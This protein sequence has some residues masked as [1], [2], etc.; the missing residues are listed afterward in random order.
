[1]YADA[2]QELAKALSCLG[3]FAE[4][5][6]AAQRA[7]DLPR[8]AEANRA[9]TSRRL[10]RCKQLVA[11]ESRL[12]AILAEQELPSDVA[13]QRALAEWLY[14]DKKLNYASARLYAAVFAKQPSLA[15][16]LVTQ[17]RIDAACAAALAG[18]GMG[19]DAASLDDA[20]KTE[21]RKQALAW[22]KAE[23]D[24]WAI[25]QSKGTI[26]EQL[27]VAAAVRALQSNGDLACLRDQGWNWRIPGLPSSQ[28][29]RLH[30]S[31]CR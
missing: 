27:S 20:K 1:M 12:P 17:N 18:C 8:M 10:E 2:W 24:A 15:D 11:I 26:A 28:S 7:I 6:D 5:R 30:S 13:T 4:A 3:R 22:F 9:S 19:A 31:G 25:R 21:L 14:K 16:D 29:W 23:R